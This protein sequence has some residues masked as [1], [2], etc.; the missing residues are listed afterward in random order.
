M[1]SRSPEGLG[2]PLDKRKH[3]S[4]KII[5]YGELLLLNLIKC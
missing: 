5:T 2:H 4:L 1:G 3:L